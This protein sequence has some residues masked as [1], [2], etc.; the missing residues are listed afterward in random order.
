METNFRDFI[1]L[2]KYLLHE[3]EDVNRDDLLIIKRAISS[4]KTI[5]KVKLFDTIL[6]NNSNLEGILKEIDELIVQ[7]KEEA[8]LVEED[9]KKRLVNGGS[10][11]LNIINRYI[12]SLEVLKTNIINNDYH[13]LVEDF[14]MDAKNGQ[15]LIDDCAISL[16]NGYGKFVSIFG[17]P[18]ITYARDGVNRYNVNYEVIEKL[19]EVFQ[20]E[21]VKS[22]LI[23]YAS[24]I[25]NIEVLR[26]R[27]ER[28]Q[29]EANGWNIVKD[30]F[31]KVKYYVSQVILRDKQ[32]N[33]LEAYKEDIEALECDIKALKGKGF[34]TVMFKAEEIMDKKSEISDLKMKMKVAEDIIEAL[35]GRIA[36]KEAEISE[37]NISDI[38]NMIVSTYS[39]RKVIQIPYMLRKNKEINDDISQSQVDEE[40]LHLDDF[41]NDKINNANERVLSLDKLYQEKKVCE[42]E[43]VESLGDESKAL[44]QEYPEDIRKI[45]T[46]LTSPDNQKRTPIICVYILKVLNDSNTLSYQD[47]N[48]IMDN[49]VI[50][51]ELIGS[52]ENVINKYVNEQRDIMAVTNQEYEAELTEQQILSQTL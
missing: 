1:E 42:Q 50:V 13:A 3:A 26:R 35:N 51:D 17:S 30:N 46:L 18:I 33:L 32:R 52:F 41:I 4:F 16:S 14:V 36:N 29:D 25:D 39:K 12:E 44:I 24:E 23:R 22:D 40:L 31:D 10:K 45:V 5:I 8:R 38:I 34:A 27:C 9:L 43:V 2:A 7:Y 6:A 20:N 47:M 49:S 11:T 37:L 28:Y 48:D 19:F 15:Q 21:D